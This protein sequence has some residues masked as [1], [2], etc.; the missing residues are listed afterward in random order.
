L[1]LLLVGVAGAILALVYWSPW[2]VRVSRR[3]SR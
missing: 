3:R 2:T 1:L